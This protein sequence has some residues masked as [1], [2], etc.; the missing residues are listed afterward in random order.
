MTIRIPRPGATTAFL[1]LLALGQF[2]AQLA[3]LGQGLERTIVTCSV[4]DTYYYLQTAWNLVHRGWVTFDGL[5]PTSG[6]QLLWFGVVTALAAVVPGKSALALAV[7]GVCAALN[8]GVYLF[9]GRIGRTL[10]R[11]GFTVALAGLWSLQH[12]GTKAYMS[13]MESSLHALTVWW[14]VSAA[15]GFVDAVRAGRGPGFAGLTAALVANAWTRYDSGLLSAVV[16]AVCLGM[17][18]A[19]LGSLRRLLRAHG[20]SLAWS[21]GAAAAA[22]VLELAVYHRLDGTFAPVSG[23]VKAAGGDVAGPFLG[24]LLWLLK[25]SLSVAALFGTPTVAVGLA[26]ALLLPRRLPAAVAAVRPVWCAL[27]LAWLLTQGLLAGTGVLTAARGWTYVW[28]NTPWVVLWILSVALAAERGGAWLAPWWRW[29]PAP[30]TVA[31]VVVGVVT[32]GAS[33]DAFHQRYTRPLD[34]DHHYLRVHRTALWMDANLPADAV[35]AAWNAG[36]LGYYGGRPVVNLDGLVN[37]AAYFEDVLRRPG[38][39]EGYLRDAGVGFVVDNVYGNITF[40]HVAGDADTLPA[41][42]ALV[43]EFPPASNGRIMK[44]WSLWGDEPIS[45]AVAP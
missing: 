45:A 21:A 6:V 7:L 28:Y 33:L 32:L 10:G 34:T 42:A 39:L 31:G 8:A 4:D 41:G 25:A 26:A 2:A 27:A 36:Q 5:H 1:G 19:R 37:S 14:L 12:F 20:R 23:L 35:C 22:L 43:H 44:V 38:S 9:I 3:Y 13:G 30:A 18:L 16:Y 15:V 29:R 24:D 40:R 11:P 17:L